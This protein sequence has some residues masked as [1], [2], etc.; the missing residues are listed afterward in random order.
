MHILF[1]LYS[2]NIGGAEKQAFELAKYLKNKLNHKISFISVS[3]EGNLVEKLKSEQ[4]E[5]YYLNFDTFIINNFHKISLSKKSVSYYYKFKNQIKRATKIISTIAPDKIIPFTYYPN[6]ISCL[7][8]KK[9]KIDPIIWNQ[10]DLGTEGFSN[11]FAEKKAL[12]SSTV[13]IGNSIKVIDFMKDR[14]SSKNKFEII[15]NG[16]DIEAINKIEKKNIDYQTA[17]MIAN[18]HFNKNHITLVKAWALIIKKTGYKNAKLKLIGR[19]DGAEK[20]LMELTKELNLENN[21]EILPG[22]EDVYTEILSNHFFVFSSLSEGSPNA[23]L[24]AM[25][26]GKVIIAS[27]IDP[28]KE[29]LGSQY[30][31]LCPSTD[32]NCFSEKIILAFEQKEL[33]NKIEK[34]NKIRVFNQYSINTAALKWLEL[35]N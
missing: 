19:F 18:F 8:C 31:F 34:E 16:I 28:I 5:Y 26:C 30:P 4:I 9:L 32:E 27:D 33:S 2:Y 21:I 25:A 12:N 29:L 35:L 24:E 11:S 15:N 10:R 20:K 22:V 3:S 23:V 17:V 14:L 6:V 1:F 7:I 13:I